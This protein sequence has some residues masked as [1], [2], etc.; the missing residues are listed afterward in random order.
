MNYTKEAREITQMYYGR[1]CEMCRKLDIDILP[2]HEFTL[3]E[4]EKIKKQLKNN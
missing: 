1:Y 2:Y 3:K 4:Y